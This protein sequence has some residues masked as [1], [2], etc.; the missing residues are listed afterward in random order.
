MS[1]LIRKMQNAPAGFPARAEKN[2]VCVCL[3]ALVLHAQ[4]VAIDGSGDAEAA[5]N[6][7]ASTVKVPGFGTQY[8]VCFFIASLTTHKSK[9]GALS[10][11]PHPVK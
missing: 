2:S 1:R 5:M 8:T 4:H 11:E 10:T 3:S 9:N 7:I 6:S